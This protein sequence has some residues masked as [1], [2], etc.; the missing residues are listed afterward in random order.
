MKKKKTM[1]KDV[2]FLAN[3]PQYRRNLRLS[4]TKIEILIVKTPFL[5]EFPVPSNEIVF[6]KG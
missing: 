4:I 1:R 2:L 3:I 5:R 6:A